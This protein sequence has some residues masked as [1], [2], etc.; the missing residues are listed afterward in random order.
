MKITN[1]IWVTKYEDFPTLTRTVSTHR[2]THSGFI[3][4]PYLPPALQRTFAGFVALEN[5]EIDHS[6]HFDLK[7][8]LPFPAISKVAE[9]LA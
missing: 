6:T 4:T 2:R 5:R 1:V 8:L 9:F 7:H 3:I